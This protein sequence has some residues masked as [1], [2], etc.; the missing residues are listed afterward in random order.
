MRKLNF[1]SSLG[2]ISVTYPLTPYID[3]TV[4]ESASFDTNSDGSF[5]FT[6]EDNKLKMDNVKIAW[7]DFYAKLS[8]W[9]IS[10]TL[11]LNQLAIAVGY[12]NIE[13]KYTVSPTKIE[14]EFS[15]AFVT[16]ENYTKAKEAEIN[17]EDLDVSLI[18]GNEIDLAELVREQLLLNL[19]EQVF[20]K[21]DCK[22]L[23]EKCGANRNLIDCN[24]IEK[25][26]DPRWS[27]LKNLK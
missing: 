26:I 16:A 6:F 4:S 27:A 1:S 13:T 12:G 25:E 19:P 20:C 2:E 22:G 23:C 15:A 17:T 7:G 10:D 14:I 9:G 8:D 18:E 5:T 24:C 11:D 3:I 21:E